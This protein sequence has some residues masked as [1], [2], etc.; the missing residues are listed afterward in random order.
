MATHIKEGRATDGELQS[1]WQ[2]LLRDFE[3]HIQAGL[4]GWRFLRCIAQGELECRSVGWGIAFV[5][6]GGVLHS[7]PREPF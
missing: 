1:L 6:L 5:Q 2:P 7:V 4:G 3:W